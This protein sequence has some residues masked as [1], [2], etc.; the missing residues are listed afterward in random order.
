M[1]GYLSKIMYIVV[2]ITSP[3]SHAKKIAES[4]LSKKLI[5]CANIIKRVDS[6]FWWQKKIDGA[7]ESLIIIKTKKNL[8]VKLVKAVKAM[9]PY[10]VPEIIALPILSG[11]KEYLEWI[12]ESYR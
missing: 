3:K 5:A 8:F 7:K 11:N 9:H 6:L 1:F 2:L 4:L 10:Q 12:D